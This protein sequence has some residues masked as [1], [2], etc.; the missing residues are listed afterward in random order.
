MI[1]DINMNGQVLSIEQMK[2]LKELGVDTSGAS[3]A[4]QAD[5]CMKDRGEWLLYAYGN[6]N[7][8]YRYVEK[9]FTLQDML[10]IMPKQLK[11]K[12]ESYRT[13]V[14]CLLMIDVANTCVYYECF[15]WQQYDRAKYFEGVNLITSAYEMLCWLAENG[16]LNKK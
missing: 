6:C 15:V 10:D 12:V 11:I 13:P 3:M 2:H 7:L 14:D 1:M 16:Y 8:S 5:T 9:T 4:W